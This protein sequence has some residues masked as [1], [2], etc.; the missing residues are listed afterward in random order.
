MSINI[1]IANDV[2]NLLIYNLD[3]FEQSDLF[4]ILNK[5]NYTDDMIYK[6]FNKKNTLIEDVNFTDFT[7]K[8]GILIGFYLH[9]YGLLNKR[10]ILKDSKLQ[11]IREK[12]NLNNKF[13]NDI[14][15][16]SK[17]VDIN[18]AK[19]DISSINFIYN[20]N[21]VLMKLAEHFTYIYYKKINTPKKITLTRLN[22]E[23][24]EH[25]GDKAALDTLRKTKGFDILTKK[26]NEYGMERFFKIMYTGSYIRVNKD[27]IP[28]LY[29]ALIK[30]CKI[31]NVKN[32]PDIYIQPGFINGC[33]IGVDN[34]AIVITSGCLSL[35]CFNELM[36]LL[37]HELGHIKSKHMLYHQMG[38]MIPYLGGLL[39]NITLGMGN[40]VCSALEVALY[41]WH[42]KS[43]LTADRA[44]LLCCQDYNA[45]LSC[46]MKISG[47][48]PKYY[49]NIDTNQ[50]LQ[51][52]KEFQN[53]FN[54]DN[55]NKMIN[56]MSVIY[57]EHPWMVVRAAELDTWIAS[58][59]YE[60][61]ILNNK[62]FL[63]NS[64]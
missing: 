16:F 7:S 26:V 15:E 28:Y 4:N 52:A 8:Q 63:S 33:T 1:V 47:M 22:V 17:E 20:P 57:N 14:C 61:I 11:L 6:L 2:L 13:A 3:Y 59:C 56:S 55:I 49:S 5:L 32:I 53:Y 38:S 41:N 37:G 39:G 45:A 12:L 60:N 30:A 24:Y 44:G 43:E 50:F 29:N 51:Q 23:D 9:I 31:L 34:T 21:K 35:L 40:I 10:D 27:N 58:G 18:N 48:P 42:R 46:M 64:Y 62:K 25:D 54:N 19:K 36:F